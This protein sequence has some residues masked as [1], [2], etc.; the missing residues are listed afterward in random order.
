M[1][2]LFYEKV[3]FALRNFLI[4]ILKMNHFITERRIFVKR[5]G[6]DS[7]ER[8]RDCGSVSQGCCSIIS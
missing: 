6:K 2:E 4:D 3:Y 1:A 7:S 8:K 5:I